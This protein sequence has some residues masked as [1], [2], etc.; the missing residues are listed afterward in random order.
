MLAS[1]GSGGESRRTGQDGNVHQTRPIHD[2]APAQAG[3]TPWV[4]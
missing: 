1:I 4:G 3:V 2:V